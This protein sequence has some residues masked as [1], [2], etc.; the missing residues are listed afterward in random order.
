[1]VPVEEAL[2]RVVVAVV[3]LPYGDLDS[4]Y[5]TVVVRCRMLLYYLNTILLVNTIE[6]I[7]EAA[8][9]ARIPRATGEWSLVLADAS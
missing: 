7:P 3:C 1:M 5:I 8:S 6:V 4:A 2:I 9:G